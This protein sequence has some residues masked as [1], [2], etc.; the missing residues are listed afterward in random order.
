[1]IPN[2]GITCVPQ[3]DIGDMVGKMT[4]GNQKPG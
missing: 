4:A 1:M 2:F 3:A